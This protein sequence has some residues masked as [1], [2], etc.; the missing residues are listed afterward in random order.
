MLKN[1]LIETFFNNLNERDA[2]FMPEI[3]YVGGT[4]SKNI[5]SLDLINVLKDK[6]K[7]AFYFEKRDEIIEEIKKIAKNNDIILVMGA[8]DITLNDF[9]KKIYEEL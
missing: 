9:A 2:L 3:Y 1:E 8:R 4:V 7:N 5:S 6:G